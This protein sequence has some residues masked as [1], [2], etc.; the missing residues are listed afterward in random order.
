MD[1]LGAL[2]VWFEALLWSMGRLFQ[3]H[4]KCIITLGEERS[5]GVILIMVLDNMLLKDN[6]EL[7]LIKV[8]CHV[9]HLQ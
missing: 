8:V 5:K 9:S 4:C 3:G 2:P 6:L 7:A 1:C